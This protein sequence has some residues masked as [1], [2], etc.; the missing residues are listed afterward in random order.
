[1][2]APL[3]HK[4][5]VDYAI[6]QV[7][8]YDSPDLQGSKSPYFSSL[9]TSIHTVLPFTILST[10]TGSTKYLYKE[11]RSLY[12]IL[13]LITYGWQGAGTVPVLFRLCIMLQLGWP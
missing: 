10:L 9:S 1:M 11:K 7:V 3:T 5:D 6:N 13:S 8:D 2:I 12:C 4:Q